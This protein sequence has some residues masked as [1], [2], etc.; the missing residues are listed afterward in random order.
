MHNFESRII[1]LEQ[2]IARID[3]A[4]ADLTQRVTA[5]EQAQWNIPGPAQG[6]GGGN[7]IAYFCSPTGTIAGASGLP[8][9]GAPAGPLAS[10]TIYQIVSGAWVEVTADADLYNGL[11][12]DVIATNGCICLL[13]PDGSYI[14]IAQSCT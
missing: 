5:L 3:L 2:I 14:V 13:N 6:G 10:Q 1:L 12:A 8:G 9:S 4:L 7:A 11:E